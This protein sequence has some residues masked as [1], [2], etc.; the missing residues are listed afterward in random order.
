MSAYTLLTPQDW[1]GY[2]GDPTEYPGYTSGS[3]FCQ[4][5]H[6]GHE[7]DFISGRKP[8]SSSQPDA[9]SV[10]LELRKGDQAPF[11]VSAGTGSE[12]NE[13]GATYDGEYQS[14]PGPGRPP[15][16]TITHCRYGL[17]LEAG[18]AS[19]AAW[20]VMTQ[21]HE[22]QVANTSPPVSLCLSPGDTMTVNIGYT[23][24]NGRNTNG[25]IWT[26]KAPLARGQTYQVEQW[27]YVDPS[28]AGR[29]LLKRDGVTLVDYHG[30]LGYDGQTN[31]FWKFGPYRH[32]PTPET[33]AVNYFNMLFEWGGS[34]AFPVPL[35]A[36][37]GKVSGPFANDANSWR[38]AVNGQGP[39][40]A[41]ITATLNGKAFAQSNI[42][43]NGDG[44]FTLNP[45]RVT[46]DGT[47]SVLVV[48]D[49]SDTCK[50]TLT[51]DASGVTAS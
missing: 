15:I 2:T 48:S 33:V 25:P 35:T 29:L 20:F 51:G 14:P 13:F 36:Q 17:M 12:R 26:D 11:D 27:M 18:P 46:S 6:A 40:G 50:L 42:T 10:R 19:T 30:T 32:G 39:V 4:T 47:P 43:T 38:V 22:D 8:W 49:G 7:W 37:L 21:F 28:G 45:I 34:V 31:S 41:T 3:K 5:V 9:N 44:T 23:D 24:A 16:R 1:A